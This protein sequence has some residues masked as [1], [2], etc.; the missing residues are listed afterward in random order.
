MG[1]STRLVRLAAGA[2]LAIHAVLVGWSLAHTSVTIDEMGHLPAG[3][4]YLQKGA[5]EVNPQPPLVKLLGAAAGL[6]AGARPASF[7]SRHS[8]S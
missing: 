7:A 3:I 1:S 6:A 5:F 4:S 2:A 8:C